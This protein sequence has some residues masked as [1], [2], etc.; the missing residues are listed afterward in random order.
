MMT[1]E[2]DSPPYIQNANFIHAEQDVDEDLWPREQ[3]YYGKT[4][5]WKERVETLNPVISQND[6]E[7]TFKQG[8]LYSS[9][10]NSVTFARGI[11]GVAMYVI[12]SAE[13]RKENGEYPSRP[14]TRDFKYNAVS[15]WVYPY[16]EDII[17]ISPK[18]SEN[19]IQFIKNFCRKNSL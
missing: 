19:D 2:Q 9:V 3:Y 1:T 11:Q 18:W 5:A 13:L 15:V 8:E 7:Q 6:I 17:D 16:N 12:V 10:K 14:S 4:N